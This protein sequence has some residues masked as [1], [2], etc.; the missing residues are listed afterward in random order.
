MHYQRLRQFGTT[1]AQWRP[2]PEERFWSKVD[3]RGPTDCWPW[4]ADDR[5]YRG[6][7]HFW[8]GTEKITAIRYSC[9]LAGIDI[10][11]G[12]H[13]DHLC[14]NPSC[15]NPAHLEPV[16]PA[17]N[18]RRSVEARGIQQSK[19]AYGTAIHVLDAALLAAGPEGM[20]SKDLGEQ[21]G[22]VL[23]TVRNWLNDIKAHRTSD[24]RRIH[25]SFP[26]V[27][28]HATPRKHCVGGCA[29]KQPA[30]DRFLEA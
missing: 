9:R 12:W 13:V 19:P 22:V 1:D 2:S 6:Y 30:L 20:F 8:D 7:G 17:E 25:P 11:S 3:R 15:V 28:D 29:A 21:T 27:C 18:H 14:R 5:D 23:S 26:F 24:R 10:P 4:T 16:T